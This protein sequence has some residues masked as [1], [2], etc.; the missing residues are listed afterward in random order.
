MVFRL[1]LVRHGQSVYNEENRF[2]GWADISLTS[3]GYKEAEQV[4]TFAAGSLSTRLGRMPHMFCSDRRFLRG[5]QAGRLLKAEGFAFDR[6]FTSVLKRCVMSLH[7]VLEESDQLWIPEE[8]CWRLNERH[9]GDLQDKA[10]PEIAN[11]VGQEQ[12]TQWRRSYA[13]QPPGDQTWVRS[14]ACQGTSPQERC[15]G[16]T[17]RFGL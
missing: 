3:E 2:T 10:K 15:A 8:K 17:K 6:A 9:Y 1:V 13:S 7:K 5:V 14:C 12:A 4:S 16:S 11:Q